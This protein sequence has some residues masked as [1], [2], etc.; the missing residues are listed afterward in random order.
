MNADGSGVRR[1][2]TGTEVEH[3]G[4]WSPDGRFIALASGGSIV[5]VDAEEGTELA[6]FGEPGGSAS[7]PA[8]K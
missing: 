7:F 6:R 1:L 3:D 2:T 5:V 8:W 4:V